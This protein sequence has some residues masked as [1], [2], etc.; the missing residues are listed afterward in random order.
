MSRM[1]G[2]RPTAWTASG[3]VARPPLQGR[4]EC[5]V[6]IVGA[7]IAGLS[8]AYELT[9]AGRRVIV[10]DKGQIGGGETHHTTCHLSNA[11]DGR[12]YVI[13]RIHGRD[14]ARICAAS[15]TAAIKRIE[16]IV[17]E[18]AIDCDFARVP[19]FLF[20]PPGESMQILD[21]ELEA[22]QEA[23][24]PGVE[25][26]A[27]APLTGFD[28]GPCLRFD[29]Q[30]QMHPLLYLEGLAAAVE[31]MGGRIFCDTGMKRLA[32]EDPMWVD[33]DNGHRIHADAVVVATN[34]PVN[35]RVAIHTK[36]AAYRSYV[37]SFRVPE[38]AVQQGLY[39][40]TTQEAGQPPSSPYH[41]LRVAKNRTAPAGTSDDHLLIIGGEDHKTGQA[42]CPEERWS[43]LECWARE[44]F[45]NLKEVAFH[46]SGQVME[47]VD[48]VAFIGR[49]PGGPQHVYIATGDSG[50]GMTHGAIAGMLIKDLILEC[51]NSWAKLYE[52]SRISLLSAPQF[53]REN[54]N[55]AAHYAEWFK[56]SEVG[57]VDEI[58]PGCGAIIRRGLSLYAVY[59][60]PAGVLHEKSAV[61]PHLGGIVGWNSAESTWDCP[62][63]GSR[64]DAEGCVLNGPANSPLV[65]V[66]PFVHL[67]V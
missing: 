49:N 9:K 54:L 34:T 17:R 16:D 51:E 30:G 42:H 18:E 64:F 24:V 67:R 2:G 28:T 5:H 60:D 37:I 10:I 7:G 8:V 66:Q 6:A 12:Y 39:W 14:G 32:D 25:Q 21:R 20:L 58:Q 43:R 11:I 40:D 27:R 61:C 44:R 31:R 57:S 53:T 55:V 52:P 19:G 13:R 3:G 22:A 45:A 56:P 15:H 26:V 38:G 23:H 46:W 4:A 29:N 62:C 50:M 59:R 33:T 47:P 35:N 48:N 41:Y 63:H 1:N 65:D 36:Q